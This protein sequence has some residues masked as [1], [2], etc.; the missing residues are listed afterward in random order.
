[1]DKTVLS[2]QSSCYNLV[3]KTLEL[4]D[5]SGKQPEHKDFLRSEFTNK[6]I[7]NN[8]QKVLLFYKFK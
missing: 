6:W 8:K 3:I 5:S 4:Y 2:S 7:F 1:M